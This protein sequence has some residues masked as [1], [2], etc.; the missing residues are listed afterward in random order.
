MTGSRRL[1]SPVGAACHALR[2][3]G[4]RLVATALLLVPFGALVASGLAAEGH[5]VRT[6]VGMLLILSALPIAVANRRLCSPLRPSH[7]PVT[8]PYRDSPTVGRPR[9]PSGVPILGSMLVTWGT[10]TGFGSILCGV[11]GMVVLWMDPLGPLAV[12]SVIWTPGASSPPP[13]E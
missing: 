3:W 11:T 8:T 13:W 4:E 9:R 2:C 12:L 5:T 10:M 6:I 1:R 7:P